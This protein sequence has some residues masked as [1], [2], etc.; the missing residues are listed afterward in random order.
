MTKSEHRKL[1][2]ERFLERSGITVDTSLPLFLDEDSARIKS[3][4][5][6]ARRA[7][8]AFFT[9][10]IAIDICSNADLQKSV[11]VFGN[12]VNKF[13]VRNDLT[14]DERRYFDPEHCAEI[15]YKEAFEMQWRVERCMPLFWALGMTDGDLDFP[16]QITNTD[17][18]AKSLCSAS[19]LSVITKI[20]DVP[21]DED[22]LNNADTA[23]RMHRTCVRACELGDPD[24]KNNLDS[25]VVSEQYLGFCWLVGALESDD[26]DNPVTIF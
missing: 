24:L 9:A 6:I 2:S 17:T 11:A 5:K 12:L 7:I 10:Q 16:S 14:A 8:A 18:I 1:L 15:T 26:W 20:A 25:D 19:D 22:I 4:E 13:G 3:R 23:M 21:S